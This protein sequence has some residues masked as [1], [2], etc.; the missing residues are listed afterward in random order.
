MINSVDRYAAPKLTVYGSMIR[1]TASGQLGS[2]ESGGAPNPSNGN[3]S[4]VN[5]P[6]LSKRP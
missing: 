3:C 5:T 2:C 1:L 4:G 6:N